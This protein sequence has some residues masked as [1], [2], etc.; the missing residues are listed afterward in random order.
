M[1]TN[2]NPVVTVLVAAFNAENYISETIQSVLSQTFKNFELLYLNS[3]IESVSAVCSV[4]H[5]RDLLAVQGVA[6]SPPGQYH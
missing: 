3:F 1:D 5:D 4:L 6:S 2:L